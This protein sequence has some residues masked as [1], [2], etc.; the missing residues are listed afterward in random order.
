MLVRKSLKKLW[1][2]FQTP[3]FYSNWIETKEAELLVEIQRECDIIIIF[4]LLFPH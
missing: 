2:L 1:K 3:L 4:L